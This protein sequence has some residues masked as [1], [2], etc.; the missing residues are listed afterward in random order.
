MLWVF[1]PDADGGGAHPPMEDVVVAAEVVGGL[2]VR[3]AD[4]ARGREGARVRARCGQVGEFGRGGG[5]GGGGGVSVS[6]E[7]HGA[8]GVKVTG[9][10]HR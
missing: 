7:G 9:C 10:L 5:G 6:L 8:V 2:A 3:V 1:V 4:V